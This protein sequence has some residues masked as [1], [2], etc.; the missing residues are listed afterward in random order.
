MNIESG[1]PTPAPG[2]RRGQGRHREALEAMKV[3]DSIL[4]QAENKAH[5][6]RYAGFHF[7]YRMSMRKCEDGWRVWR[8]S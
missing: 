4:F 3:G 7:G 2:S 5:S 1:I 8:I 6:F